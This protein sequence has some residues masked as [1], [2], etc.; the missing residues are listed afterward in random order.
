[1]RAKMLRDFLFEAAKDLRFLLSRGYNRATALKF[2]GDKYLLDKYNRHIL[3]RGIYPPK[4]INENS[5][6]I[7]PIKKLKNSDL[8]IDGF[9]LII[10]TEAILKGGPIILCDDGFIRDTSAI[11]ERFRVSD[12]TFEALTLIFQLLSKYPPKEIHF[13]LDSPISKSGKLAI[14]INN[15]FKKYDLLGAA[16]TSKNV[17]AELVKRNLV[18]TSDHIIIERVKQ[19]V[20]IPRNFLEI[21][22]GEIISFKERI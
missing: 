21:Y 17:D 18:A 6:K 5:N 12:S 11:F 9:N 15:Y 8:A 20:D 19:V 4:V 2:V 14:A 3:F 13:F 22:K 10:T 7:V 1:M 16:L